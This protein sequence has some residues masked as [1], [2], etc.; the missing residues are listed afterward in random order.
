MG[1]DENSVD[2]QFAELQRDYIAGLSVRVQP[3]LVTWQQYLDDG[4]PADLLKELYRGV[5]AIAGTAGIL[6]VSPVDALSNKAQIVLHGAMQSGE[7]SAAQ[8]SEVSVM[9]NELLLV[10]Q[11]GKV[12]VRPMGL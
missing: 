1:S 7:M 11:S 10:A 8:I 12:D 2:A 6:N 9:L 4:M 5:H 3:I